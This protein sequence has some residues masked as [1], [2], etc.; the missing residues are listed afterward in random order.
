MANTTA[1]KEPVVKKVTIN[2]PKLRDSKDQ[3]V[4]VG[5]NDE[6]YLIQRGVDVEVPIYVKEILDN[7]EKAL[8]A[9]DAFIASSIAQD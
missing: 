6:T 1:K 4:F 9:A 8:D 3:Q 5:V 7:R 2:L